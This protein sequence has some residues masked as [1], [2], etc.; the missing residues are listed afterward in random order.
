MNQ[1]H[2]FAAAGKT[3]ALAAAT[4]A[5][6]YLG[7]CSESP[8]TIADSGDVPPPNA[9]ALAEIP[10]DPGFHRLPMTV[11]EPGIVDTDGESASATLAPQTE[12]IPAIF[13][14]LSTARLTEEKVLTYLNSPEVMARANEAGIAPSAVTM[15]A[16]VYTPA[17]IR[18]AYGLPALPSAAVKPTATQAAALGSGQTIYIIAAKHAPNAFDDL[19]RFNTKFGLP[20]CTSLAISSTAKLPLAAATVGSGCTFSV[21]YASSAAKLNS[22]PPTYD[23]GWASEMSLDVQ[24][25]HA[26]APMARIILIEATDASVGALLG[27]IGVANA[28]GPGVVSMSFGG[29][30]GSWV[31]SLDATFAVKGMSYVAATGDSGAQVNWP[32]VSPNVLAVGGTTLAYSGTAGRSETMWSGTGGGVS[33]FEPVPSYQAVTTIP[34]EPAA[35]AAKMRGLADVAFNADP[36]SGQFVVITA[37]GGASLWYSFGGTSLS[38][39]QWAGLLAVSNA[40]RAAAGK[41]MAGLVHPWPYQKIATTPANYSAAFL[42]VTKGANG[43]AATL[44]ARSGFDLGTGLGTPNATS[45]LGQFLAMP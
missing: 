16:T 45:L 8:S 32:A 12:T 40:Q 1:K 24:W 29:G 15:A 13:A 3:M 18:A 19:S 30:E 22:T 10:V 17:Q 11:A 33:I 38:T 39:P 41:A 4:T 7:G 34:G 6:L 21:V 35:A 37:P 26:T 44:T 14:G 23:A 2:A 28:M 36:A 20:A 31:R 27:A 42:D 5:L 43:A 25:S 9:A